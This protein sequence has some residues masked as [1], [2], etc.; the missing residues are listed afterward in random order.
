MI[1]ISLVKHI[2]K[3]FIQ[4]YHN[5][6]LMKFNQMMLIYLIIYLLEFKNV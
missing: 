4:I 3:N 6:C 1:L 2:K 5:D